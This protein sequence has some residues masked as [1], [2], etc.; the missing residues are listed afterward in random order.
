MNPALRRRASE[1]SP[2]FI[3]GQ[4]GIPDD[5]ANRNCVVR[6]VSRNSHD[7]SSVGHD[8]VFAL[9]GDP[10]AALLQHPNRIE[11]VD[12]RKCG[13]VIPR[14]QAASFRRLA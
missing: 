14:Q 4:P 1:K 12:S 2:E 11:V 10:K 6:I 5:I 9:A 13:H 7:P 3:I 8:D